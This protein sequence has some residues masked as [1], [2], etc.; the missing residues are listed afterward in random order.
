MENITIILSHLNLAGWVVA[1]GFGL[2][3]IFN[4]KQRERRIDD[5]QTASNLIT[6]LKTSLDIQEKTITKMQSDMEMHSKARDVQIKELSEKVHN[7]TG[8]NGIL[9]DLFKGRDPAMQNF[10]KDA[11]ILMTIAHEN[12]GLAKE[13]SGALVNLTQTIQSLVERLPVNEQ[14]HG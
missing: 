8:R 3:G 13:T 11:P 14:H 6:N 7:L 12:N 10:L 9:E 4:K 2:Y 1:G 5:D